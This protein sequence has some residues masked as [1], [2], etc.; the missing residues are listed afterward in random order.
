[1]NLG[2]LASHNGSNMQAIIDACCSGRLAATP[3]VVIS[4]NR[5]S[6]ALE[7]ARNERIPRFHLS[8]STHPHPEDLDRE[9]VDVL[10]EH[11][12]NLVLLAGYMK[13][14]GPVTLA[15]FPGHILN[16]HPGLL[17]EYGG[18]GMY[19]RRVHEAVLAAGAA[20]SGATVHV[21]DAI[22]DNGPALAQ[23]KVTVEKSDTV[24]TLGPARAGGGA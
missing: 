24:D 11:D 7:R 10:L 3:A 6:G 5:D 20:T 1:M 22:Y 18:Q 21:V 13:K 14:I 8:G 19:G 17:P 9:I 12:V 2:F 4:N 16:I 15:T 23:R